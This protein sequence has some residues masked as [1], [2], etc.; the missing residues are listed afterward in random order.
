MTFSREEQIREAFEGAEIRL[1]KEELS[2]LSI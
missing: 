1:T 2:Y